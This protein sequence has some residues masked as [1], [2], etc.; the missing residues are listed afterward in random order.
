MLSTNAP[1]IT[2]DLFSRVEIA[3]HFGVSQQTLRKWELTG[4]GPPTIRVGRRIFYRAQAVR[5]W[6][7]DQEAKATT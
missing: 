3:R 7:L 4:Q 1:L 5:Q 2:R 6:L